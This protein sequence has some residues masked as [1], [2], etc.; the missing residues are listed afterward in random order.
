MAKQREVVHFLVAD[1]DADDRML[2]KRAL[3]QSR[4]P[5]GLR[6]V[7]DGEALMDYLHHRGKYAAPE[8]SPRPG[9]ILLELNLPRIDGRQALEEIKAD[10]ELRNIPIAIL[11]MSKQE[12][13]IL[14]SCQLGVQA[15]I[16]KP[17]TFD[18][19]AEIMKNLSRFW[20]NVVSL[21]NGDG[22]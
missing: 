18:G 3:E 10:P 7:E 19:L 4:L 1:D 22:E 20:L 13:D 2:A 12:E 9:V 5:D 15:Y 14:R 16:T 6:F 8:S 17:V 21:P 11:T